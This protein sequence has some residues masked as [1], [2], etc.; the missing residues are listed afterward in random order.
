MLTPD[1]GGGFGP[2]GAPYPEE[3]LVALAA[4]RLGRPVKWVESRRED[5]Q[6]SGHD[7]EQSH[8]VKIGF[9]RT[10]PS[11]A[12]TRAS[13]PTWAPIPPRAMG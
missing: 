12:S 5:F 10:A 13:W 7:R 9:A 1:V 4:L 2:K 8:Q 11:P 6:A 3:A